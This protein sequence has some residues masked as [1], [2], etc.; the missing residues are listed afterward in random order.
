MSI[1]IISNPIRPLSSA[2]HLTSTFTVKPVNTS[3]MSV[4]LPFNHIS[5]SVSA[6]HLMSL[7]NVVDLVR[8]CLWVSNAEPR[9]SQAHSCWHEHMRRKHWRAFAASGINFSYGVHKSSI[10]AALAESQRQTEQHPCWRR[11]PADAWLIFH[12]PLFLFLFFF[13]SSKCHQ[14]SWQSNSCSSEMWLLQDMTW[15]TLILISIHWTFFFCC[16][17]QFSSGLVLGTLTF[18]TTPPY[19]MFYMAT[20]INVPVYSPEWLWPWWLLVP[21]ETKQFFFFNL[22]SRTR[23]ESGCSVLLLK[24]IRP[25]VRCIEM[26]FCSPPLYAVVIRISDTFLPVRTSCLSSTRHFYHQLL[27]GGV[28]FVCFCPHHSV[29]TPDNS[30][31]M[32]SF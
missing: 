7:I 23:T 31:E 11:T 18:R 24:P 4:K 21:T 8:E 10:I 22:L 26:L 12:Y 5:L 29:R 2:S 25:K 17:L 15:L 16:C 32:S 19:N 13:F 3:L 14:F 20:L 6:L 9:S 1:R 30:Q 27:T 28:F